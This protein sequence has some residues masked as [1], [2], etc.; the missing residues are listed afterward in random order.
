MAIF[1]LAPFAIAAPALSSAIA[2]LTATNPALPI[3]EIRWLMFHSEEGPAIRFTVPDEDTTQSAFGG[4]LRRYDVHVAKMF[5]VT[6]H[7]CQQ[8]QEIQRIDWFYE[9]ANSRANMGRFTIRCRLAREVAA[10]YGQKRLEKTWIKR[11]FKGDWSNGDKE[12]EQTTQ[13]LVPVLELKGSKASKW[14][15]FVQQFRPDFTVV[16]VRDNSEIPVKQML[17]SLKQ[18][19][20]IPLLLPSSYP[21]LGTAYFSITANEGGYSA[22][23]SGRPICVG[24]YA[25]GA[26]YFTA[27]YADR[28]A[29]FE[30]PSSDAYQEKFEPVQL[31]HGIQG[32]AISQWG[33][34]RRSVQWEYEGVVYTVHGKSRIPELIQIA[35]SAIE[36][37]PR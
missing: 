10:A 3:T 25:S 6:S 4:E 37:G 1:K 15:D 34:T 31:A 23:F 29:K 30:M 7:L 5:E 36:A 14:M 12:S 18:K 17:Q 19:P 22:G 35:N 32:V 9:A 16:H 2:Q 27:I 11:E 26:C 21:S 24:I 28:N 20:Q 8:N 33:S 13:H